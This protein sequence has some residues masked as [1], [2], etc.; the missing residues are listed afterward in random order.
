MQQLIIDQ[1][2]AKNRRRLGNR[3]RILGINHCLPGQP[4]AV[5]GMSDLV[6]EHAYIYIITVKAGDHPALPNRDNVNAHPE[7]AFTAPRFGID[8]AM[9][10]YFT[11]EPAQ[12]GAEP[13][14]SG[15]ND[16]LS[17]RIRN[18]DPRLPAKRRKNIIKRQRPRMT[19]QLSLFGVIPVELRQALFNGLKH[20]IKRLLIHP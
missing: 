19:Q 3:H 15:G 20:H 11:G 2:L 10:E 4:A 5:I 7:G 12:L 1:A 6:G 13:A 18:P 9:L 8:P 16:I 17:L 14:E